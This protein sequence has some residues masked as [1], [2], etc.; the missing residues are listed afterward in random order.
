MGYKKSLIIKQIALNKNLI[1]LLER[2]KKIF[3]LTVN[4]YIE[5]ILV[6]KYENELKEMVKNS[7]D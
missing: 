3:N 7:D 5:K 2:D 4:K 6:D 1:F